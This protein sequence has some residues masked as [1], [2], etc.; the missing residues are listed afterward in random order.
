FGTPVRRREDGRFLTG[1]ARFISNLDIPGAAHVVYVSSSVAHGRILSVDVSKARGA[2][3]VLGAYTADDVDLG[4]YPP[5]DPTLDPAMLRPVLGS[6]SVRFVG[7]P[8]AVIVGEARSAAE[9]AA[10]LVIVEIEP[11]PAVADIDGALAGEVLLF[12]ET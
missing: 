11:L 1:G 8:V 10:E 5:I 3:G 9:D 6:G 4:P 7:E 12:P 2:P